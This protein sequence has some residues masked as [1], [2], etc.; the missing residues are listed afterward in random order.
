MEE[1]GEHGVITVQDGKTIEDELTAISGFQFDRGYISPYFITNP[2]T[3]KVEYDNPLILIHEGKISS[4]QPLLPILE[5]VFQKNVPLVIVAEDVDGDAIAT[6]VLNRMRAQ[7]RIV[8]VKAPGF[9]DNRKAMLQDLAV[10]TGGTVV[11]A[12]F[13]LTLEQMTI[14][15]LGRA[16]SISIS[17]DTTLLLDGYG[18]TDAIDDRCELIRQTIS[19]ST[20]EYEK[21]KLQ[22]RLAKLVGGVAVIKVGGS[23]EVEVNEKKDR[24]D[25]ALNATRAAVE[26]GIVPGGG[27][28]LLYASQILDGAAVN[29]TIDSKVIVNNDQLLG[30]EIVK[31]AI[32]APARTIVN[33]AGRP[34]EVVV[35]NLLERADGN[36]ATTWGY[37]ASNFEYCD[38]LQ[39]GII[40]P[41]KVVR[42]ALVDASGVASLMTTTEAMIV[43]IPKPEAAGHRV[44]AWVAWEEWEEWEEWDFKVRE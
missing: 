41:T 8:A 19:N 23:S 1:V 12:D 20:S 28:A 33:N 13:D 11:S 43:D 15:K 34:G 35:N 9:G 10:C 30:V 29:S 22:E 3:Q 31:E 4:I 17:K 14:D 36:T 27:S 6:L 25:D 16:K 5:A 42:T 37:N 21:E 38:L 44:V 40:D 24:V 7:S 2:K 26:E 32:R 39:A 18:T